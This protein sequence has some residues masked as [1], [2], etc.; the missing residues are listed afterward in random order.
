MGL[1]ARKHKKTPSITNSP[2]SQSVSAFATSP[3]VP[4]VAAFPEVP[5]LSLRVAVDPVPAGTSPAGGLFYIY[6]DP[7]D[8]V[9][10]IRRAVSEKLGDVS[11]GMFKVRHLSFL[12]PR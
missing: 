5:R 8:D 1:F 11:L 10:A 6:V 7:K 2:T 4:S 3:I 12:L 9:S